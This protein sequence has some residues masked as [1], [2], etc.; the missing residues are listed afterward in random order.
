[1]SRST[2][3]DHFDRLYAETSDPCGL[4]SS[5]YELRKCEAAIAALGS[6]RF[7]NAVEIGCSTGILTE[8]LAPNCDEL[9]GID[10]VEAPLVEA[11]QRCA[12]LPQVSFRRMAIPREWPEGGF[13][14]IVLSKIMHFMSIADIQDMAQHC[15]DSGRPSAT[16]LLV[17][18]LGP[19]DGAVDGDVA[20]LTFMQALPVA[21]LCE[22]VSLTPRYRI[23]VAHR[24]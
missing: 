6:R 4:A 17:N 21:W 23:D 18:V 10:W 13:D 22:N 15:D 8:R 14:L 12:S 19:N 16:I 9:V 2:P 5:E 11:R 1:M 3:A 20:A 7:A 24:R